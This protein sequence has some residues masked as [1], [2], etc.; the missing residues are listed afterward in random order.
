MRWAARRRDFHGAVPSPQSPPPFPT[1][2]SLSEIASEFFTVLKKP[3]LHRTAFGLL[4]VIS[5]SLVTNGVQVAANVV[6]FNYGVLQ[7]AVD[8]SAG[9]ALLACEAGSAMHA[10]A[11]S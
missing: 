3:A 1:F 9:F 6:W 7:A 5:L 8:S 2:L 10:R 4:A 11:R